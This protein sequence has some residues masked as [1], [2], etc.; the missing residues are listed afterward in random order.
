MSVGIAA[1]ARI[2]AMSGSGA[3][4][5]CLCSARITALAAR[6]VK[7]SPS[8]FRRV[9]NRGTFTDATREAVHPLDRLAAYASDRWNPADS[10]C[11]VAV[12]RRRIQASQL[13]SDSNGGATDRPGCGRMGTPVDT[14][15]LGEPRVVSRVR[16]PAR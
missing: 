13:G 4:G 2:A 5:A 1:L 3:C 10:L 12:L 7:S 6:I 11:A 8:I 15:R 16:S 14:A 9:R